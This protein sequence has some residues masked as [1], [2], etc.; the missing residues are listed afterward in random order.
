MNKGRIVQMGSP[1]T[2]YDQPESKFAAEFIGETNILS[3]ELDKRE[4]R[5]WRVKEID[6]II[7]MPDSPAVRPISCLSIRPEKI[8]RITD[9]SD[10]QGQGVFFQAKT[11]LWVRTRDSGLPVR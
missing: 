11:P 3:L 9:E 5:R 10:R 1:K 6:R 8:G 4:G 7:E 2:I